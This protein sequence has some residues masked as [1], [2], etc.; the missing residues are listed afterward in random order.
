M[1]QHVFFAC[2][3]V[4]MN[5]NR[6]KHNSMFLEPAGADPTLTV[7]PEVVRGALVDSVVRANYARTTA[8]ATDQLRDMRLK[9]NDLQTIM[10]AHGH[11][12]SHVVA[13]EGVQKPLDITATENGLPPR[14]RFSIPM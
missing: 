2:L 14:G 9:K 4:I 8:D 12:A 1:K 10:R 5:V 3:L 7:P 11:P 13:S 6:K